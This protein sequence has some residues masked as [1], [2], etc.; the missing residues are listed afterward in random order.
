MSADEDCY[1]C[2]MRAVGEV[3]GLLLSIFNLLLTPLHLRL[4]CRAGS[5]LIPVSASRQLRQVRYAQQ[6][7]SVTSRARSIITKHTL[8]LTISAQV[9]LKS[10]RHGM[11]IGAHHS[12]RLHEYRN[13]KVVQAA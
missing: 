5:A 13:K 10:V 1:M 3:G 12:R 8:V 7:R 11:S 2:S 4:R 6:A 9:F